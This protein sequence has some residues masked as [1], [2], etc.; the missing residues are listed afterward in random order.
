[1]FII[2][3]IWEKEDYFVKPLKDAFFFLILNIINQNKCVRYRA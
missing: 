1:M 2:K 3:Y